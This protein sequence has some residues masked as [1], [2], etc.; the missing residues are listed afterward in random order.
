M[1]WAVSIFPI[2]I[3]RLVAEPLNSLVNKISPENKRLNSS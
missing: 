2:L 3:L 1:K